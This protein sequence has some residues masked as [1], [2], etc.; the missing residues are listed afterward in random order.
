M[1]N[2]L[3]QLTQ[4][5]LPIQKGDRVILFDSVASA[6]ELAFMLGGE[7]DNCNSVTLAQYD[8]IAVVEAAALIGAKWCCSG[9]RIALLPKVAETVLLERYRLGERN[10]INAN[11]RCSRLDRQ[12]LKGVNLSYA[13]LQLADLTKIDLRDA[14]LTAADLSNANLTG[15]NLTNTNLFRTNL[16][17]ANLS[18]ANLSG[19]KLRKACFKGANLEKADLRGAD[20]RGADLRGAELDNISFSRANL[21]GAMLT[22]EQ[23]S[24]S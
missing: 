22:A 16:N 18:G 6:N 23:L 20:L 4:T 12:C 10:F 11:L 13:F 1:N 19:A 14:D 15:A 2:L 7:W 8:R 21:T 3:Q 5:F 24:R 9:D 17:R